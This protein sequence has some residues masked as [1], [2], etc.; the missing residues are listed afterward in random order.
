MSKNN[1]NFPIVEA[2][3]ISVDANGK[4]LTTKIAE[5]EASS[6]GGGGT[7]STIVSDN[8]IVNAATDKRLTATVN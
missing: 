5:L 3:D 8:V 7:P 4:R 2:A 6:G 1:G